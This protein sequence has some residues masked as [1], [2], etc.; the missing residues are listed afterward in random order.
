MDLSEN[1][2]LLSTK[3]ATSNGGSKRGKKGDEDPL[4]EFIKKLRGSAG[5]VASYCSDC[6]RPLSDD[7][8]SL[9]VSRELFAKHLEIEHPEKK[10]RG[11]E[12]IR[13][14]CDRRRKEEEARKAKE[15]KAAEKKARVASREVGPAASKS[16][17]ASPDSKRNRK[18]I[19]QPSLTD[20][21]VA[22][23]RQLYVELGRIRPVCGACYNRFGFSSPNALEVALHEHGLVLGIPKNR[24][25]L[26]KE[27]IEEAKRLYEKEEMSI[28]G[29]S[30]R[31][32]V[33]WGYSL[34]GL[35]HALREIFTDHSTDH[36]V[37]LKRTPRRRP[38][39]PTKMT[40]RRVEVAWEL[41]SVGNYSLREIGKMACKPWEYKPSSCEDSIGDALKKAG[42]KLRVSKW[43]QG[44]RTIERGVAIEMIK[45][46]R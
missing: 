5:T 29:I 46:A 1:V 31:H 15:R 23:M 20:E 44:P 42:Y 10:P 14:E 19:R 30:R 16:G 7:L 2:G 18:T 3:G 34:M 39:R 36:S 26:T 24:R 38:E 27:M 28:Y 11:I 45:A 13:E 12:V 4:E 40:P 35:R 21:M 33:S 22:E 43:E 17:K 6:G 37:D 41:Y 8:V 9:S 25:R 32:H